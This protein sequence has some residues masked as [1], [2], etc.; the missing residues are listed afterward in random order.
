MTIQSCIGGDPEK[1]FQPRTAENGLAGP[2][3]KVADKDQLL[4]SQ[5]SGKPVREGTGVNVASVADVKQALGG[6]ES[7]ALP[8]AKKEEESEMD[9]I[10]VIIKNLLAITNKIKSASI[11]FLWCSNISN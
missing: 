3:D 10:Q 1:G 5:G 8:V 2:I 9:A 6:N 7:V 11:I 4:K